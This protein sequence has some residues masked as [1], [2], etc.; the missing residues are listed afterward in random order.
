[1]ILPVELAKA[2]RDPKLS[3]DKP[4]RLHF[5]GSFAPRIHPFVPPSLP[6]PLSCSVSSSI[7]F[8]ASLWSFQHLVWSRHVWFATVQFVRYGQVRGSSSLLRYNSSHHSFDSYNTAYKHLF[9]GSTETGPIAY[10]GHP[11]ES[12]AYI[13]RSNSISSS[14]AQLPLSTHGIASPTLHAA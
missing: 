11:S 9:H 10:P 2:V 3:Q 12:Q 1:M 13:S 14:A 4:T 7:T 5:L 8:S 6:H